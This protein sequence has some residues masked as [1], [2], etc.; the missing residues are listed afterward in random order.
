MSNFN[1]SM[2]NSHNNFIKY[3]PE[4]LE[5]IYGHQ[6]VFPYWVADMDFQVAQPITD[7][8]SRLAQR[9]V[10][11]YEFNEQ[12]V[13]NSIS[14]WHRDRNSLELSPQQFVQVPGVLSG[15]AMIVRHLTD[16][17]D[18]VLIHT[19]A[20]H[21]FSNLIT[22]AGRNVVSSK[23]I[24]VDGHY[25]IDFADLDKQLSE[26]QVKVMIFCNPH[27]PT[28]RVWTK[29]ELDKVTQVATKHDVAIISDEIHADIVYGDNQFHSLVTTG[30]D[31]LVTLLGSPAKTFGMHSIAN[32]YIYI[33]NETLF[34]GFKQLVASMYLD[35]G[36]AISTLATIAAY[37]K[38][39]QWL[40]EMNAYLSDTVDWI[41]EFVSKNIP[42]I[43]MFKPQGTYQIWFDFSKLGLS[44]EQL[45]EVVFNRAKV[46]LT[47]GQWFSAESG[48]YMRMN[49]ATDRDNIIA[50]F[51]ALHSVI[52]EFEPNQCQEQQAFEDKGCCC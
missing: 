48:Q 1:P 22:K 34:K 39:H 42:A 51:K 17:G 20:Y 46:G 30:Y 7:E 14:A 36:N 15:I 19:P 21:Q 8:I 24:D 28:G 37:T 52:Q 25:E 11:S 29:E 12:A 26:H 45:R 27:N 2:V 32:G 47:P 4:M 35:H 33:E 49:I 13:F 43:K 5:N 38:G 50:S 6:D 23:L 40:D 16:E 41:D 9:G 44:V 18:S 10:F 3:Q 31:K